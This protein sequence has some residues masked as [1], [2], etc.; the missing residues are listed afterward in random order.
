MEIEGRGAIALE[1]A[2]QLQSPMGTF[3]TTELIMGTVT[4]VEQDCP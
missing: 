4:P 2:W 1:G 3:G